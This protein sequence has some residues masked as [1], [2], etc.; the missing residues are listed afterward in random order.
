[1]SQYDD[2]DFAGLE[3]EFGPDLQDSRSDDE[4]F[5]PEDGFWVRVRRAADQTLNDYGNGQR[6]IIH[7]G[8]DLMWVPRVG[9]FT[10]NGSVW[11]ADPDEIDVKSKAHRIGGLIEKETRFITVPP[12]KQAIVDQKAML[13]DEFAELSAR[14]PRSADDEKRLAE[15]RA[16]RDEISRLLSAVQDRIGQR[17]RHAKNAGNSGPLKNMTSEASIGLATPLDR[18]DVDPL[19]VNTLSGV[20]RFWVDSD[21]DAGMSRVA[22]VELLPHDRDRRL[23]KQMPVTYDPEAPCPRFDKFLAEIQPN[24]EM[25]AFLQRWFGLSMTGLTVQRLAFF[26]GMGAN[27]KSVL[28][29]LMA[30]I[31]GDYA[32]QAKIES[33]TGTNRR[34][35]G[36]ATPDLVPMIGARFLRTSEPDEGMRWQEGLIKELT[37]GEPMLVRAL[38]SDFVTFLPIF[39]LTISGNH[40]PDIRGTDD[41]IWRRLML[42]E[43]NQQIPK[44]KQIPKDELDAILFEERDGIFSWMVRG[45]LD[46]LEGGLQEPQ[47]VLLATQTFREE[48]DPYGTYLNEVC[49]ITGDPVDRMQARDLVNGFHLWLADRAEGAFQ[50]RTVANALKERSRRWRSRDGRMF[51]WAKSN[52][53]A[54]YDGIRFNDFFRRKFDSSEKDPRTGRPKASSSDAA[55]GYQPDWPPYSTEDR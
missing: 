19:L 3:T 12:K 8:D 44:E 42:V 23:T 2:D 11:K 35:G 6:Y 1:M 45:L 39:K 17:L 43:F 29:D 49:I 50:D 34:G 10:W 37:G 27:G 55:S 52:G 4:P 31:L 53:Q 16:T 18:L 51:T 20:L 54:V 21:P 22:S 26:Y 33:L 15:L 40:K 25:R 14:K 28:V 24:P 48:S 9:W 7:F 46:F 38:H 36:D 30:R 13:D 41:G 32:A 47:A 5:D